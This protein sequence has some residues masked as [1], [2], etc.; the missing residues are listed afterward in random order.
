MQLFY[1]GKRDIE[2]PAATRRG[3]PPRAS[4]QCEA[5]GRKLSDAEASEG[6]QGLAFCGD[7]RSR[8]DRSA[9]QIHF[10]DACGVSVPLDAVQAGAAITPDGRILC[11]ACRAPQRA[12][13]PA[14]PW[15]V[16]LAAAALVAG[17]L[18][19]WLS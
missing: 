14:V 5:C 7:C 2:L 4:R 16:I 10:C 3:P 13:R 6:G 8:L 12:R 18:L 11:L 1:H 15:A 17:A 19:A 9:I